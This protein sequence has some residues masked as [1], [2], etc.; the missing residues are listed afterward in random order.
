[1]SGRVQVKVCG[2]T[3]PDDARAAVEAG[4]DALGLNFH[5]ASP[6]YVSVARAQEI[7]RALPPFVPLVGVFVDRPAAEILLTARKAGLDAVQ[8]HGAESPEL[9]DELPLRVIRAI[10]LRTEADLEQLPGWKRAS[11]LLLDGGGKPGAHGGAVFDWAL[12]AEARRMISAPL[13]VA[14]GLTPANVAACITATRP[15]AVDVSSGV[16]SAPGTKSA[17]LMRAFVRAVRAAQGGGTPA[18]AGGLR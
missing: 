4:A 14:G 6:R 17:D 12:A 9:L 1:M 2:V 11:A 15:Q 3:T 8:L 7:R 13:I 10:R 16:E 5:P 18:S